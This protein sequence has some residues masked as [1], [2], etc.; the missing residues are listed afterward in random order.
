MMTRYIHVKY[1]FY[2]L[3]LLCSQYTF[4]V[5]S[6]MYAHYLVRWQTK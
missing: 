1:M 6:N 4:H 5:T 3:N 2:L